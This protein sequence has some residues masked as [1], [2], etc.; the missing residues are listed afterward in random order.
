MVRSDRSLGEWSQTRLR[1]ILY[2]CSL[3]MKRADFAPRASFGLLVHARNSY[4]HTLDDWRRTVISVWPAESCEFLLPADSTRCWHFEQSTAAR[5]RDEAQQR[6]QDMGGTNLLIETEELR[7]ALQQH[8]LTFPYGAN[9]L[10]GLENI[11]YDTYIW[12]SVVV[13]IGIESKHSTF[14]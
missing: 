7:P 9:W 14:I 3:L 6:C 5:S 4:H 12:N 11:V 8:L 2:T 13:P 1:L 10:I